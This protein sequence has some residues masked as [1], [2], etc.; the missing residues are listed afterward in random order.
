MEKTYYF[1]RWKQYGNG[2]KNSETITCDS[3]LEYEFDYYM[4]G[5][6]CQKYNFIDS[7]YVGEFKIY[8][9]EK[10]DVSGQYPEYIVGLYPTMHIFLYCVGIREHLEC[11]DY[12]SN[13]AQKLE[14]CDTYF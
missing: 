11:I 13:L 14:I 5:V 3:T 12:L 6:I 4:T 7:Y 1:E 8:I 10:S 9:F 2:K